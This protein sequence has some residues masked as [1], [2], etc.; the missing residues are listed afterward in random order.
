[1]QGTKPPH[2]GFLNEIVDILVI[3]DET[4]RKRRQRWREIGNSDTQ[5]LKL[6][7]A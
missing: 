5:G 1:M 7:F 2:H 6:R 3:S 4:T